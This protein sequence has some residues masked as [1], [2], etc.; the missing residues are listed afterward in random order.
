MCGIHFARYDSPMSKLRQTLSERDHR[1]NICL[2][3]LIAIVTIWS[4]IAPYDRKVWMLEVTP[5]IS[6]VFALTATYKYYRFTRL[7]YFVVF[8]A[9]VLIAIGGHYTFE[10]VPFGIWAKE[11][12]HTQR[13]HYDRAGH[14][15]QGVFS[16]L[17]IREMVVRRS[18]VRRG[19]WLFMLVSA[20]SLAIATCFEFVEWFVA[21]T[22]GDGS[23][24]YLATQGDEW[25]AHWDMLLAFI[26]SILVQLTLVR[27]QEKQLRERGLALDK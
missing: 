16:A 8:I 13:N 17:L 2:L 14:F 27:I 5:I 6:G 9:A 22:V 21:V 26:G 3:I 1:H 23:Q 12:F 20:S 25:D 19:K 10:R 4:G 7:S 15:M 11:F 18:G 24:A